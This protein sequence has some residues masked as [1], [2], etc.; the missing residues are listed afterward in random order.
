MYALTKF[1]P[2]M[3]SL[4]SSKSKMIDLYNKH[5]ENMLRYE[6]NLQM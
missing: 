4:Q 2:A 6:Y 1:Q 5:W 3:L